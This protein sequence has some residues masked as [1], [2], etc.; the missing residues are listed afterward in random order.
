M[1]YQYHWKLT[2][3]TTGEKNGEQNCQTAF[4]IKLD[5]VFSDVF[6]KASTNIITRLLE[7]PSEKITD[8]SMFRTKGMKA[9]DVQVLAA[10]D[11]ELCKLNLRSMILTTAEK[12]LPQLNLI[13]AVP[14]IKDFSSIGVLSEI[15][16]DMSVFF[17]SMQLCSW[18]GLT[19]KNNESTRKKKTT[20]TSRAGAYIKP[21][22]VQCALC[23]ICVKANPEICACYLSIK[24]AGVTRKPLSSS[25]KCCSL[26]FTTLSKRMSPTILIFTAQR[27]I[28][29]PIGQY[30]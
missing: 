5:N 29:P 15:G 22:L 30:R 16:A 7:K 12:Y 13:L 2:D 3:V 17:F 11:G 9:T 19:P 21:L 6:G 27:A 10:V 4:N 14:G 8:V 23:A 1:E 18:V 26:P 20:R 25:P 28:L 24:S